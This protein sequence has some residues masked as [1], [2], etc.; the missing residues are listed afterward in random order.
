MARDSG[1]SS[2]LWLVGIGAALY[3]AYEWSQNN[4]GVGNSNPLCSIFN[5]S[6]SSGTAAFM[7]PS[8][9]LTSA[10]AN[11]ASVTVPISVTTP[12]T[13]G[14]PAATFP[15]AMNC[16][17]GYYQAAAAGQP[18]N[19]VPINSL[20]TAVPISPPAGGHR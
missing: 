2:I 10:P 6:A 7:P 9:P 11:S 1:D 16:P 15:S 3:L 8:P 12:P 14:T 19:C 20:K 17:R 18:S 13:P 4:C 5:P